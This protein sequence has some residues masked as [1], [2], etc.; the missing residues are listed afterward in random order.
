MYAAL[1]NSRPPGEH[2]ALPDRTIQ[3]PSR[4]RGNPIAGIRTATRRRPQPADPTARSLVLGT[5]AALAV[6]ALVKHRLARKAARHNPPAGRF[7]DVDGIRP[8]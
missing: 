3:I 2:A 4:P 1:Q 6:S 8:H 7:L 5:I